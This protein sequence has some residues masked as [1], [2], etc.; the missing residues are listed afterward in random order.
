[1]VPSSLQMT[2]WFLA[3]LQHDKNLNQLM[4]MERKGG[5]IYEIQKI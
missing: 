3:Q 1:M 5:L 4:L 2:S